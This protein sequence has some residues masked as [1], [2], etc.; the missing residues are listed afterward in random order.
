MGNAIVAGNASAHHN[1]EEKI[2]VYYNYHSLMD[3]D[4]RLNSFLLLRFF[5]YWHSYY[6]YFTLCK[7]ITNILKH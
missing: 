6:R 2:V 5:I 7:I 3:H 1:L 4:Y